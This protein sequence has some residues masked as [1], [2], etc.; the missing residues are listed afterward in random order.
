MLRR[1][2]GRL[3]RSFG[4]RR[5][6]PLVPAASLRNQLDNR[7]SA[8]AEQTH[9]ADQDPRLELRRQLTAPPRRYKPLS[10]KAREDLAT[11]AA[12]HMEHVPVDDDSFGQRVDEFVLARYPH[13]QH[14]DVRQMVEQGAIYRYRFNGKRRYTKV[15]DRLERGELLVLPPTV[16]GDAAALNRPVTPNESGVEEPQVMPA[17]S[18]KDNARPSKA[19]V[20]LSAK[21][22]EEA[23][24]WVL[25]KNEHV[26]V[27]NKPAGIPIMGGT[28]VGL[29]VSDML[30]AWRFSNP[31]DPLL[32]HRLDQDT[33][34]V[35]VLARHADAQRMLGRMF[36]RRSVPNSVYWAFCTGEPAAKYGRIRMHLEVDKVAGGT[37]IVARMTPTDKSRAAIAEY[38]VN[39]SANE[40]GSFVSFY[41]LTSQTSQL[42]I[43]AAHALGCPV[44]GDGRFGGEAAFP[45]GLA[46]FWDPDEKGVPLHLHHRKLQ[47]PY[48]NSRGEFVTVSAPLP[49]HMENTFRKL[50]WPTDANDP[51]VPD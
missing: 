6:N 28:G 27:V 31:R 48:K 37:H 1:G 21:L 15:T 26:I 29:N 14:R 42:R 11:Q 25:F 32:V 5:D 7:E 34:G 2:L 16:R 18:Y 35:L 43:M 19:R 3:Q 38:V 24:K 40:Y 50:G 46:S 17:A 20:P 44:L 33:S 41:P 9:V 39:A 8:L 30:P 12:E 4:H 49:A 36:V 45:R 22:R 13:L 47:L 10:L 51:L 23:F